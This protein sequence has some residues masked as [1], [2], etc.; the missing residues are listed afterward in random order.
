MDEFLVM[1][2]DGVRAKIV[3]MAK[4]GQNT[5]ADTPKGRAIGR[6]SH[7]IRVHP[8]YVL[9]QRFPNFYTLRPH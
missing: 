2:W 9:D 4:K 3:N 6:S 8:S 7:L 1:K 5:K